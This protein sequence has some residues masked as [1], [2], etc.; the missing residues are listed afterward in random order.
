MQ[1]KLLQ[2]IRIAD[3]TS[4]VFGPYC[5]Q[6]LA[7]LG[8]DVIKIEP[9]EG[10][11]FRRAGVRQERAP[12]MGAVHMNL[13]RSK[14]S[15]VLDLKSPD[16]LAAMFELIASCDVFIHNVR[17][18][19][20]ARLGLDYESVKAVCPD[21]IYVH[22]VGFGSSGPYAH[23]QAYDDI[24]Q[25]LAGTATLLPRVDGNPTPRYV[26][27]LIADKVAGLY[28]VQAVQAALIHQLRTGEGQRVE[29]PMF[30]AFAQFALLEHLFG[31]TWCDSGMLAGYPR[32]LDPNRQPMRTQDGYVCVVPYT[33][34]TWV[35]FFEIAGHPEILADER[36][37]TPSARQRHTSLLNMEMARVLQN[38]PTV[39]WVNLL[40]AASIPAMPV[41]DLECITDDP[42]LQATGF[43]QRRHHA[44]AGDY[45]EM[46]AP[47]R[48]S[49][50]PETQLPLGRC[51][52][53]L[54]EHTAEVLGELTAMRMTARGLLR[55]RQNRSEGAKRGGKSASRRLGE[56]RRRAEK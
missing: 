36:F 30:E 8:A 14:R 27:S 53:G 6:C 20:I 9:P 51:A 38:R 49:A 1:N 25:S 5:T 46:R 34:A 39:E 44:M 41:N 48:F 31:K 21:I 26:P 19:A 4:V 37:S 32:Q 11:I 18:D 35:R 23:L 55:A 40:N 54:G 28:A 33:D 29:V 10:D 12:A 22:C 24:I 45:L 56:G 16:G 17:Q 43:F 15:V 50:L 52:P 47:L 7:D 42:H 13:N 2:G 3:L